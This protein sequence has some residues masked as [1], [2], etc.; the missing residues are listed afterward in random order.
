VFVCAVGAD[1]EAA[2][3]AELK[4]LTKRVAKSRWEEVARSCGALCEAFWVLGNLP[5]EWLLAHAPVLLPGV[6]AAGNVAV[7]SCGIG[8]PADAPREA[9][10]QLL[11][12]AFEL[13]HRYVRLLPGRAH[14]AGA[15]WAA[16]LGALVAAAASVCEGLLGAGGGAVVAPR[17]AQLLPRVVAVASALC[18]SQIGAGVTTG[19]IVDEVDALAI[20]D[21]L[22]EEAAWLRRHPSSDPSRAT[23]AMVAAAA[24]V[25]LSGTAAERS[26][27]SSV[28]GRAVA[29][30]DAFVQALDGCTNRPGAGFQNAL[31]ACHRLLA[32]VA[33]RSLT[34]HMT[35]RD[36]L[37]LVTVYVATVEVARATTTGAPAVVAA[38][39][40]SLCALL[41][42]RW[43]Q[44]E[45][46]IGRVIG[47]LAALLRAALV[48]GAG[49]SHSD[50]SCVSRLLEVAPSVRKM[51]C[52]ALLLL[53]LL[54]LCVPR[55]L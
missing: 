11:L 13:L 8:A 12:A 46:C 41:K 45:E 37:A 25:R 17:D 6:T 43:A 5:K 18:A 19:S 29:I 28:A 26:V 23:S 44:M 35:T 2:V 15:P 16:E 40:E 55:V 21:R 22:L 50:L 31:V 54:L 20:A 38:A 4:I 34:V 39:C 1:K 7:S 24:L 53:L 14:A 10:S 32:V 47:V 27:K 49:L 48:P 51:R 33:T 52:R 42:Y 3:A 30:A 9:L 36:A